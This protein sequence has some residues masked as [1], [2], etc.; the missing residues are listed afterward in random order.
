MSDVRLQWDPD[1]DPDGAPQDR[2]AIQLG[3]KDGTLRK[4][5][6]EWLV[7]I[8]DVSAFV[9]AQREHVL[10]LRYDQLETPRESVYSVP[11]VEVAKR[12]GLVETDAHA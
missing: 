6:G 11:D 7:E 9:T 4:Y 5:A 8:E 1:H 3:M 12:L 2:R 10:A